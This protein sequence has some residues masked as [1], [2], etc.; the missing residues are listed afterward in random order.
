MSMLF[1]IV[2]NLCERCHPGIC[3]LFFVP[4]LLHW[5][6]LIRYILVF[7]LIFSTGVL[8]YTSSCYFFSG[9][10]TLECIKIVWK[11]VETHI[12]RPNF[13]VY[14]SGSRKWDL[15]IYISNKFWRSHY[16]NL[17]SREYDKQLQF[18][19]VYCQII[20]FTMKQKSLKF[21][22]SLTPL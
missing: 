12:A 19:P 13:R 21:I 4:L 15:I 7:H 1:P 16:E 20:C 17:S 3:L 9:S 2:Y 10:K 22:L 11:F 5:A 8:S 14:N 6:G 18:T